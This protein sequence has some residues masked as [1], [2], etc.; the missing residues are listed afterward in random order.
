M[1]L[2]G[3]RFHF[4]IELALKTFS[5]DFE[6]IFRLVFGLLGTAFQGILL[7]EYV[8]GPEKDRMLF[9]F[10]VSWLLCLLSLSL[11]ASFGVSR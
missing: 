1:Q 9:V 5:R 4:Y 3:N 2:S 8:G 6:G 7:L 11:A 10:L